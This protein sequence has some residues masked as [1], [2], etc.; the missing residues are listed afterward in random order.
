MF[1]AEIESDRKVTVKTVIS[2]G[3]VNPIKTTNA[4]FYNEARITLS[5]SLWRIM[6][7]SMRRKVK[8]ARLLKAMML[9]QAVA[10]YPRMFVMRAH[11]KFIWKQIWA[12]LSEY[13]QL[14]CR[15]SLILS[16]ILH[17]IISYH[18]WDMR[19][20]MMLTAMMI[21]TMMMTAGVRTK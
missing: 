2:E 4:V 10:K 11:M 17:L 1:W 20:T 3:G 19:K 12:T 16:I 7:L 18:V 6:R 5:T 21:N 9:L 13:S 14:K 15:K 8:D